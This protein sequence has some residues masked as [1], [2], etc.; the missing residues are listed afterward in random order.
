MNAHIVTTRGHEW[1][2]YWRR[3]LSEYTWLGTVTG[4]YGGQ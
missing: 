3:R 1:V 4:Y 2:T